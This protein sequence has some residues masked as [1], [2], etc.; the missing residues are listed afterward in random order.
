MRNVLRI[1][2]L[3]L[4]PF[5]LV[6]ACDGNK[7]DKKPEK[8]A[9][10][11]AQKPAPT[12][13]GEIQGVVKFEGTVPPPEPWGGAG[14]A[15]CRTLHPDTIQLVKVD[16]GKLED[17]FVYVKSGL[18]EGTYP[19]PEAKVEFDQ[20]GCE[21][22][23]RVFGIMAGQTMATA[24]S[25]KLMHNVKSA[26]WNQAFPFGVKKDMKLDNPA[27]MNVIKCDVHPWMRAYAGVMEHP[28]F[29]VTKKDG[30]FDLKGLV[31]GEYTVAAWHEKLGT[32]EQKV[33]VAGGAPAKVELVFKK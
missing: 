8:K 2:P 6:A 23:P 9:S 14:N 3:A 10:A 21:F 11:A 20:K 17:A 27:V 25:D 28:Y 32:T 19:V 29:A 5:V 4:I 16:D 18:P 22:S 12:G 15:D 30:A 31:D 1:T 13:H 7:A 26:E 33:K 24:N